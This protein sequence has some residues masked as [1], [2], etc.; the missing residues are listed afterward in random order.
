VT[1]GSIAEVIGNRFSGVIVFWIYFL[2]VK[3]LSC[4]IKEIYIGIKNLNVIMHPIFS[5]IYD[6]MDAIITLW[7]YKLIF[8]IVNGSRFGSRL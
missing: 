2:G 4:S 6:S 7:N 1:A 5:I 3:H 8:V